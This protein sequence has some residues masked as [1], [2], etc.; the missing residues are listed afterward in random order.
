MEVELDRA[1]LTGQ[2]TEGLVILAL[3]ALGMIGR[4]RIIPDDRA[5]WDA[6]ARTLPADLEEEVRYAWDE[7]ERRAAEGGVAERILVRPT[8]PVQ[9]EQSPLLLTPIEALALLGRPLR[10]LLENGRNDRA[11]ILAFADSATHKALSEAEEAGWIVF[12]TAGGINELALR[13]ESAADAA[14][15]EVF[16]TMYL[17]DSDAREPGAL[18]EIAAAIQQSLTALAI[19]LRRPAGHFGC[20]LTRR[21]AENYAPPGD[22]LTW[23]SEGFG[24]EA[25]KLIQQASSPTERAMLTIGTGLANSARRQLLG[26]IALRELHPDVRGFLD[27]KEG[28]FHK[29]KR[30]KPDIERTADSIWNALDDFQRAALL[31]GFGAGF[32]ASF[33]ASRTGL[34]DETGEIPALLAKIMERV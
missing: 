29:N 32:S 6:W 30:P 2:P 24:R 15:R 33:Y 7:G 12:E 11:F 4:H 25:W 13:L 26:A 9:F 28:R 16:R 3:C 1:L 22:V 8:G 14:A 27:M 20:V 21:A 31:D 10:I 23:A 19:R 34:G 18:T 17:C 5:P